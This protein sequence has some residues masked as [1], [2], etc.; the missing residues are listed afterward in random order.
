MVS[1]TILAEPQLLPSPPPSPTPSDTPTERGGP[2]HINKAHLTPEASTANK[3]KGRM[4]DSFIDS[5][6]SDQDDESE[7]YP[8]DE[9]ETKRIEETLRK[10]EIE[11][12]E[13]RRIARESESSFKSS[14]LDVTRRASLI[15][16][17]LHVQRPR[18]GAGGGGCHHHALP[19]DENEDGVALEDLDRT[20]P[21]S[22]ANTPTFKQRFD[23]SRPTSGSTTGS[24]PFENLDNVLNTPNHPTILTESSEPPPGFSTAAKKKKRRSGA[25]PPQP[26]GL[27]I[28]KTPP[29]RDDEGQT[30]VADPPEHTAGPSTMARGADRPHPDETEKEVKWW[31]EW[32]CGCSEGPDRGGYKQS[33]RT[34]PN[35]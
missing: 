14:V 9:A 24:N 5:Q 4:A 17:G 15:W 2:G 18:S 1:K 32:L 8:P 35:E 27:P 12:R 28:P 13:R 16:A 29:P 11:E 19:D 30:Y 33:G 20:P 34:N 31:T 25:P 22:G 10:W 6:H 7:E 23:T 26:L 3:G 21:P